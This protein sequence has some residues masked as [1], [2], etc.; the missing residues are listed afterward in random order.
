MVQIEQY[1]DGLQGYTGI[2][3]NGITFLLASAECRADALPAKW[4]QTDFV[5]AD[6]LPRRMEML[7]PFVT[8][9]SMSEES[10]EANLARLGDVGLVS[11]STGDAGHV[12]IDTRP[13]GKIVLRRNV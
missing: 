2:S 1:A 11:A 9:L 13:G 4:R 5:I 6:D 12:L 8:V 3:V 10:A 7:S